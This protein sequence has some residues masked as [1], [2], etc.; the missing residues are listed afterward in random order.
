MNYDEILKKIIRRYGVRT[1]NIRTTQIIESRLKKHTAT[2]ADAEQFAQEIGKA[3]TDAFREYLPEAL[4]DG[5]LYRAAAEVLVEQPMK[6]AGRDVAEVAER[7][8]KQLNENAGLGMNPVVP[9]MNQDQIDGMITG[10]CNADSY[11]AGKEILMGQV[12]N[13]LEG[14]VDAFVRENADFQY[15]AGLSPTIERRADGKCCTWCSA[16]AGRYLYRDVSDRGNDVFRRHRNCHCLILFNPGDGS[17]RRQNVHT[18]EF[19]TEDELRERQLHYGERKNFTRD[20]G[21][22]RAR[23]IENY[24]ENN[25]YIDQNVNLSPRDVRR[26]NTQITQAKEL[27]GIAG[28]CDAPFIIVNDNKKLAAYNPRKNEFYISSSLANEKGI[29]KL[30][31]DFASPKDSRS[32][33]VHELF[34]WKDAEEYRKSV[35]RITSSTQTSEYSVYQREKAFRALGQA[36][37]DA[38]DLEKVEK[39]ISKHAADAIRIDNDSEEAYTE[40]RTRML[41]EGGKG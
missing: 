34:H 19:G 41:I 21:T 5:K 8:Q 27:H 13:C 26:I 32:T 2:Y 6:K 37:F 9:K 22:I 10:I 29:L 12:G 40:Y 35:G 7:I 3:L 1:D 17:R 11:E 33:M 36:G 28:Q 31:Q 25:L 4:T 15:R 14:Y 30:Q 16:L 39:G 38:R 23:K 20:S 18:R 24:R